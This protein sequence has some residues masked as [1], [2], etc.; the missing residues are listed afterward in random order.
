MVWV[1]FAMVLAHKG[2]SSGWSVMSAPG[3]NARVKVMFEGARAENPS[4]SHGSI[5]PSCPPC[6]CVCV[7][8][9][10]CVSRPV[11]SNSLSL[12]ASLSLEFSGQEY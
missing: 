10:V 1:G 11:V 6:V 7:C 4:V 8:V 2:C 5:T 9:Y 3:E 12:Q